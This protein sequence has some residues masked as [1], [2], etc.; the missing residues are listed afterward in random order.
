MIAF[1]NIKL[2]RFWCRGAVI[3]EVTVG[4][5]EVRGRFY[6]SVFIY[7]IFWVYGGGMIIFG[8]GGGNV[9]LMM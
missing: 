6:Y 5:R 3:R 1:C 8:V 4:E 2:E 7:K 9:F